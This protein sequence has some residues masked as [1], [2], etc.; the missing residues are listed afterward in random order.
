MKWI[1]RTIEENKNTRKSEQL[2]GY[3]IASW[4]NLESQMQ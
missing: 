1:M 3:V 2:F 4:L